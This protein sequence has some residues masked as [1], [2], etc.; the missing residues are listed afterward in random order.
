MRW[1]VLCAATS[2]VA[3]VGACVPAGEKT[4][5]SLAGDWRG[6]ITCYSI[7]SPLQ[8]KIDHAT[9]SRAVMSMGDEG[10]LTW[11]ASV[12]A[13]EATV[14]VTSDGPANGAE[15]ISGTLDDGVLSGT[16]TKQLCTSFELKHQP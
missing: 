11:N 12:A 8:M 5:T 2:V 1:L 9:P 3:S 16:M 4:S 7:E 15:I 14:T 6:K 10:A 13:N